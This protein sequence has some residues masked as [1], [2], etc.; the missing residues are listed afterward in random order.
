MVKK[1][2][3]HILFASIVFTLASAP[4]C[5]Q[6]PTPLAPV[7]PDAGVRGCGEIG[8]PDTGTI[9]IFDINVVQWNGTAAA[10]IVNGGFKFVEVD[11]TG[12]QLNTVQSREIKSLTV[13]GNTAK[14]VAVGYWNNMLSEITLTALDDNLSGDNLSIVA[15]PIMSMLPVIYERQGGVIS[16]DITVF[17]RP[18]TV[19]FARGCG[20]IA[21]GANRGAFSFYARAT[22]YGVEGSASY[23]EME[24][25]KRPSPM[26]IRP[27]IRILLPKITTLKVEG[28]AAYMEGIGTL[29]EKPAVVR[30]KCADNTNPLIVGP[31]DQPD[32]FGIEAI[33]IDG[34]TGYAAGGA[35]ICGDVVVGFLPVL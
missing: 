33:P 8:L 19:P 23:Y 16:G 21:I 12:V 11:K 34:S 1:V 5:A 3:Q 15:K 28:R 2:A 22:S 24:I 20:A 27:K 13:I 6:Q 9:G 4:I 25:P 31:I 29:N 35:L 10:P 26:P 17:S 18:L 32:L 30:L 14:V 7:P